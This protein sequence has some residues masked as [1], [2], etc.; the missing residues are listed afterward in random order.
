MSGEG[1]AG[2]QGAGGQAMPSRLAPSRILRE[3]R[4]VAVLRAD[5]AA[6]YDPVVDVLIANGV[7]S[8]EF[9]LTTPGTL[10]R[11]PAIRERVGADAELGVGTVV[12]V[13]D[14]HRAIDAGADYLVTPVTR[15]E[16]VVAAVAAGVP[17]FPG[18]L[19]PTE[20]HR[21]WEL[22]ATAVKVFPAETVGPRYG[23]HLRGPFPGLRFVPSGGVGLD[24]IR[25]WLEAG[26]VAVSLGG[27]LLGDALAGGSL[28]ALAARARAAA[29]AARPAS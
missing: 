9:T 11:L 18:G 12:S 17:V 23:A 14:V 4:V 13:D 2:G 5:D 16:V 15:D 22:G 27:P 21:G 8:I 19:T 3:T 10:A 25:P 26:A 20:L 6:A 24:D 29:D 7:R 28:D 1:G